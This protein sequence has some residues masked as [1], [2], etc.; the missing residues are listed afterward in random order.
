[1]HQSPGVHSGQAAPG[2]VTSPCQL[3]AGD[4][5]TEYHADRDRGPVH[6]GACHAIGERDPDRGSDDGYFPVGLPD[7]EFI[8]CAHRDPVRGPLAG[9]ER[10]GRSGRIGRSDRTGGSHPARPEASVLNADCGPMQSTAE[11]QCLKAWRLAW[12]SGGG[13][14]CG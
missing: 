5:D 9:S 3:G 13:W 1:M 10:I 2:P 7:R 14:V 11:A 4:V 12:I 8:T 6:V